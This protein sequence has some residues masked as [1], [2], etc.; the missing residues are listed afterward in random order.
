[1]VLSPDA[2]RIP[3]A[4]RRARA[5]RAA[6]PPGRGVLI[7]RGGGGGGGGGGEPAT[8]EH[9]RLLEKNRAAHGRLRQRFANDPRMQPSRDF[10]AAADPPATATFEVS[11]ISSGDICDNSFTVEATRVYWDGKVAIYEDDDNPITAAGNAT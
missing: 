11:D 9:Y 4:P 2:A 8:E 1:P 6:R 3:A 5:G 7:G 10:V